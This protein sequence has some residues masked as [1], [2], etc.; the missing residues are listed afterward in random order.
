MND[1]KQNPPHG[2][3]NIRDDFFQVAARGVLAQRRKSGH[4][5]R[6]AEQVNRQ[7]G[8]IGRET[9]NSDAS[10]GK[11]GSKNGNHK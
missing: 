3:G 4:G 11:R 2:A 5:V 10:G 1:K 7:S 8:Q 6:Q 9:I